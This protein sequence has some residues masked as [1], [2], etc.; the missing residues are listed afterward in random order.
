MQA[1]TTVLR[2]FSIHN[3][4]RAQSVAIARSV[5]YIH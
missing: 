2:P 1:P 4:S 3:A 5:N